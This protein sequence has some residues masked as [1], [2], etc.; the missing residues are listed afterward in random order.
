[1]INFWTEY[2]KNIPMSQLLLNTTRRQFKIEEINI[3]FW[4][5]M[6]LSFNFPCRCNILPGNNKSFVFLKPLQNSFQSNILRIEIHY[7][8]KKL[9]LGFIVWNGDRYNMKS[10]SKFHEYTQSNSS[11]QGECFTYLFKVLVHVNLSAKLMDKSLPTRTQLGHTSHH[12]DKVESLL[13]SWFRSSTNIYLPYSKCWV[14]RGLM[15]L[16]LHSFFNTKVSQDSLSS[17]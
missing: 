6:L 11:C 10:P 3:I 7:Q 13:E 5:Y 9:Q 14:F 1:M 8:W 15:L 2:Q 12:Y 4:N 16:I 17:A